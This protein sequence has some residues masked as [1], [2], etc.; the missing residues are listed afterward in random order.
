MGNITMIVMLRTMFKSVSEKIS[1][2]DLLKTKI[3]I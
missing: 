1:A 3:V 2:P